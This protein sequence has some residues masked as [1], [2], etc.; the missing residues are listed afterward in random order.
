MEDESIPLSKFVTDNK[1]DEYLKK[2]REILAKSKEPS[3]IILNGTPI[4]NDQLDLVTCF[5]P[6]HI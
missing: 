1:K 2:L 3:P 6:L 5:T 4:S